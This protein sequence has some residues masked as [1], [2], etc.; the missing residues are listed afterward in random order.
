MSL[1][2][3]KMFV[4]FGRHS[5]NLT[6]G[7]CTGKLGRQI[8]LYPGEKTRHTTHTL[9]CDL[10]VALVASQLGVVVP[11]LFEVLLGLE[12]LMLLFEFRVYF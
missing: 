5:C 12:V 7:G 2:N 9:H 10:A 11:L 1:V 4:I 8:S 3:V 6:P